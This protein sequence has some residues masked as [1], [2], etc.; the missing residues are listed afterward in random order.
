MTS[1][2]ARCLDR[3]SRL[4]LEEVDA[5][6]VVTRRRVGDAESGDGGKDEFRAEVRS[7]SCRRPAAL[8]RSAGGQWTPAA[9]AGLL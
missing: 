7:A 8:R 4:Q 3:A 1:W 5:A 9:V 2:A 6:E